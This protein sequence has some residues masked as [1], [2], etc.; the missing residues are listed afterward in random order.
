M[1]LKFNKIVES[2]FLLEYL[3]KNEDIYKIF[4]HWKSLKAFEGKMYVEK[5]IKK[6]DFNGINDIWFIWKYE[7]KTFKIRM[8]ISYKTRYDEGEIYIKNFIPL[9]KKIENGIEVNMINKDSDAFEFMTT[10]AEMTKATG[11]IQEYND[12]SD[13]ISAIELYEE[14]TIEQ[15]KKSEQ[16]ISLEKFKS[17]I[18]Y[19]VDRKA[20]KDINIETFEVGS[21]VYAYEEDIDERIPRDNVS[22]QGYILWELKEPIKLAPEL[23]KTLKQIKKDDGQ[24]PL[25]N[26]HNDW[27]AEKESIELKDF[28]IVNKKDKHSLLYLITEFK[29]IS[30]K[31]FFTIFNRL[32]HKKRRTML[33]VIED[34]K[35]DRINN[36][37]LFQFLFNNGE[38]NKISKIES[39]KVNEELKDKYSM[40]LHKK[41]KIAF[42]LATDDERIAFIQGPPG[43]GKT[44]TIT[45]IC[46]YYN[47]MNMKVLVS[48]QT[49]VAVENILENLWNDNSY[50][51][52]SVKAD[53][54]NSKYSDI[55]MSNLINEKI[56]NIVGIKNDIDLRDVNISI[57]IM[58]SNVIGSTTTSSAITTRKWETFYN[59]IDVLI[60][61]EISKSSVP[62][63]IRYVVNAKKIIFVGDQKQLAPLDE[64]DQYD[65]VWEKYDGEDREIIKAYISLSIFDKLYETMDKLKRAVMLD[66]NQRSLP[67]ITKAYSYF[68][69]NE[70][71]P[72]RNEND[73]KIKWLN[74]TK[75]F[76]P[77]TFIGMNGGVEKKDR[78]NS[79]YNV[80]EAVEI[81][82]ILKELVEKI[83]NPEELEVAI[84]SFYGGQI[85]EIKNNVEIN[86]YLR[87]FK[88][89][90][91]DTVDAFQG[92][93]ADIVILSTV[94]ADKKMS[95]G[96]I[97]DYRRVNVAIS[98]AKDLIIMLGNDLLLK[99]I[100]MT[101]ESK[102]IPYYNLLFN[103]LK[104]N[105]NK[106]YQKSFLIRKVG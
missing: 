32:R 52:I 104:E 11:F 76:S 105:E 101:I 43:T 67:F 92:D 30:D 4:K 12:T 100:H 18:I 17:S 13:I 15:D 7:S 37:N 71:Q 86:K 93:Q 88:N 45:Q 38:Y 9:N 10:I 51:Y 53:Y 85:R 63:L 25:S 103:M 14:I 48:S 5:E 56:K 80:S 35:N 94:R 73:S 44:H 64:I 40:N 2:K 50:K 27:G 31:M 65:E 62:E 54:K 42:N 75:P 16:S 79:R 90:K 89:I 41:Q 21:N 57:P 95:I 106:E 84:I 46:K 8:N 26:K 61:D 1:N 102:P 81:E 70:L 3:E 87:I 99:D 33:S 66:I 74:N 59:R 69:N 47:D 91:I 82:N 23:S 97:N 29:D 20:I 28:S 72:L 78:N 68:Y 98:R 24:L 60:I 96:F 83:D 49:N 19:S 6:N 36:N 58:N 34:I 77:F 55:N 39:W 22:K